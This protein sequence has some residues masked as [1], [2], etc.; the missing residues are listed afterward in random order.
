M[1]IV[2]LET[3]FTNYYLDVF[4]YEKAINHI[5]KAILILKEHHGS[6][7]NLLRALTGNLAEIYYSQENLSI[8][9]LYY[10]QVLNLCDDEKEILI[11]TKKKLIL[12]YN[13]LGKEDISFSLIKDLYE[14]D[15]IHWDNRF[16]EIILNFAK[17]TQRNHRYQACIDMILLLEEDSCVD[18]RMKNL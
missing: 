2:T 6:K 10:Q 14:S 13:K 18:E 7:R 17:S 15:Q 8:A 11:E 4:N 9:A 12:I 16:Y 1:K 3:H 5:K